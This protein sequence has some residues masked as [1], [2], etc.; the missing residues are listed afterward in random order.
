MPCDGPSDR[1]ETADEAY[2]E[3]VAMLKERYRLPEN[4][5]ELFGLPVFT[6]DYAKAQKALKKALRDLFQ[7]ESYANW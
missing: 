5:T 3:I 2:T 7:A 6:K 4:H 1:Q